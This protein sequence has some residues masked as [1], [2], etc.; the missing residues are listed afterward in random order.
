MA[1]L[2][3][4]HFLDTHRS[5]RKPRTPFLLQLA[6]FD[7]T[8][9]N[10]TFENHNFLQIKGTGM[11]TRMGPSYANL[12]T[13]RVEPNT[14]TPLLSNPSPSLV[15]STIFSLSGATDKSLRKHFCKTSTAPFPSSSLGPS[16]G[17]QLFS[18]WM[19]GSRTIDQPRL[20]FQHPPNLRSILLRTNPS[21]P[22][23]QTGAHAHIM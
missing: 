7:L 1:S 5:P 3:L 11:G 15:I 19:S 16:R 14:S 20:V 21:S 4:E 22:Q 13:G 18:M 23:T 2:P 10:V 17:T 8:V 9:Y 12:F 6:Q